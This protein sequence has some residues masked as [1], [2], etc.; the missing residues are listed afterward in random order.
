MAALT[1]TAAPIVKATCDSC[2]RGVELEC[3]GLPAYLGYETFNEYICPHC[4]K[5]NVQRTPGAILVV[6]PTQL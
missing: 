1:P 6:R 5:K 4:R 2:R 3:A